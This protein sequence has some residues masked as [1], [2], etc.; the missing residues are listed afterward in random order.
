MKPQKEYSKTQNQISLMKV[1]STFKNEYRKEHA[2]MRVN[3][4]NKCIKVTV[5]NC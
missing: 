2:I 3:K 1:K 4:T 5:K